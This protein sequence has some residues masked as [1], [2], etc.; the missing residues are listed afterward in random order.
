MSRFRFTAILGFFAMIAVAAAAAASFPD[1]I[2]LP[3]GWRPEGVEAGRA[4]T[5]YV[6]SIGT[7]AVRQIDARTGDQFT[8]VEPMAGRSAIGLEYDRK[9]RRLFVAGGGTGQAYVY[10]AETGAPI[11]AYTLTPTMPTF[12]N[13]AVLTD[14]A[15]YFTESRRPW[16]Y[17]LPLGPRGELPAAG[18]VETIPLSWDYVQGTG[19]NLNGIVATKDGDT[20]IAIQSNTAT[21]LRIDPETGVADRIE[22]TGGDATT[23][24]DGLLL[25]GRTLYIVQNRLNRVAVVELSKDYGS[26]TVVEFLTHPKLDVP[27]TIDR[28]GSRLYLPNARFGIPNADTAEYDVIKLGKG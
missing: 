23:N 7:G 19:N 15:V 27:T 21:L 17:R 22:I 3:N 16:L 1:L 26:G 4:N 5:L 28:L 20:L 2:P 6:G 13:D 9:Y 18:E 8:L 25:E 12:I 24:G 14:D 11:A 10:D